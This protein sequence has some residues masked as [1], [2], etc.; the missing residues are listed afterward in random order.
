MRAMCEQ[1]ITDYCFI[2]CKQD[3]LP[4]SVRQKESRTKQG[5][6]L[7][8]KE[9]LRLLE[10]QTKLFPGKSMTN[11]DNSEVRYAEDGVN[12]KM[13]M[14]AVLTRAPRFFSWYFDGIS[15]KT[16]VRREGAQMD[17]GCDPA[18]TN[19]SVLVIV[20][21]LHALNLLRLCCQV[22]DALKSGSTKELDMLIVQIARTPMAELDDNNT[23]SHERDEP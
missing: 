5:Q 23:E 1:K 16:C 4:N 17:H 19:V 18:L 10:K 7:V 8:K 13:K 14:D 6:K 11:E 2:L 21:V 9:I 15:Q 3:G 20:N 22:S 12:R